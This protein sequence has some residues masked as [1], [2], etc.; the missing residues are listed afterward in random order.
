MQTVAFM[1]FSDLPCVATSFDDIVVEFVPKSQRSQLWPGK[2]GNWAE[3]QAV[4][5]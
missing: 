2:F 3:I 5:S 4:N 1:K